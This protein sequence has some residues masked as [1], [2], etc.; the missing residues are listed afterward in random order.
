MCRCDHCQQPL[1]ERVR[2][3]LLLGYPACC[4]QDYAIRSLSKKLTAADLK[5][6]EA[7]EELYSQE[8]DWYEDRMG[9]GL[10]RET[11]RDIE[12]F[13]IGRLRHEAKIDNF[14]PCHRCQHMLLHAMLEGINRLGLK[15]KDASIRAANQM[16]TKLR[17]WP[18]GYEPSNVEL[19]KRFSEVPNSVVDEV[20]KPYRKRA[21]E[22]LCEKHT[23]DKP[24][25]T[26]F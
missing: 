20:L 10:T 5:K 25:F 16:I 22:L 12:V 11:L 3:G 7:V 1:S 2:T 13:I 24:R 17:S 15:R 6:Q 19:R 8:L 23:L 14:R 18:I 21:Q 9:W 26:G 4:V